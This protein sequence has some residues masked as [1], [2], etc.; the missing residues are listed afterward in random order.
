MVHVDVLYLLTQLPV[1]GCQLPR[2]QY[3]IPN[4]DEPEPN[5]SSLDYGIMT[6]WNIEVIPSIIPLLH[7]LPK[8]ARI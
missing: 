5:R 4:L 2:T 1:A 8:K 3:L 6:H 7:F